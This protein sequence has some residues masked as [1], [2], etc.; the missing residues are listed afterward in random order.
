MADAAVQ[1]DPADTETEAAPP[2][3]LDLIP[4]G[5][6]ALEAKLRRDLD[7]LD[8]PARPWVPPRT[9]RSGEPILNALIVGGGQGGLAVAFGLMREKVDRVL[10]VDAQ[11]RD[12]VSEGHLAGARGE[13]LLERDGVA[14]EAVGGGTALP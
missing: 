3:R 7:I 12:Q 2:K 10:V 13:Q 11:P 5:L 1:L 9:T 8:Y 14:K 4:R 6:G